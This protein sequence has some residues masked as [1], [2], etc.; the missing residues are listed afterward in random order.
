MAE[1]EIYVLDQAGN[2]ID[3]IDDFVSLSYNLTDTFVSTANINLPLGFDPSLLSQDFRYEIYRNGK[4]EGD[5]QFFVTRWNLTIG[6]SDSYKVNL[7]SAKRILKWPIVAY[8][9][10]S[11]QARKTATPADDMMKELVLENLGALATDTNR[12]LSALLSVE[13]QTSLA[14]SVTKSFSRRRIFDILQDISELSAKKGTL[15]FFDVVKFGDFLQFQTYTDQRGADLTNEVRF[16]TEFVN[17][18]DVVITHDWSELINFAYAGG[19]GEGINRDVQVAFETSRIAESLWGRAKEGFFNASQENKSS[20]VLDAAEELVRKGREKIG[21]SG[22]L[23]PG[24]ATKY[25]LDFSFGD[26]VTIEESGLTFDVR[27]SPVSVRVSE[28]QEEIDI[29]F[30]VEF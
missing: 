13:S 17:I 26:M 11:P 9:A 28:G 23:V 10:G 30:R 1:F 18:T 3:V 8:Y 29:R 20:G 15:L 4:L 21:V 16:G 2:A 27:V 22:K 5:T 19:Q 6:Q 14:P 7:W 25:N 12:D 24:G